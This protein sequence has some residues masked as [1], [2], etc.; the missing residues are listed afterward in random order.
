MPLQPNP[1]LGSVVGLLLTLPIIAGFEDFAAE[2]AETLLPA[3][4]S[5]ARAEMRSSRR[6]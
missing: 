2:A 1:E 5:S 4:F 6:C 3:L